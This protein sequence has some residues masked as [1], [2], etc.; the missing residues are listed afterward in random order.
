MSYVKKLLSQYFFMINDYNFYISGL[1][2]I[3]QTNKP[4]LLMFN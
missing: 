4:N 1:H 3:N 2:I